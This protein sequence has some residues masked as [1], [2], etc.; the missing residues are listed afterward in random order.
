M[1]EAGQMRFYLGK[2]TFT[3]ESIPDDY[4]GCAG[5]AQIDRLQDVLLH[6]CR[7]GHRH[8]V[9]VTPGDVMAPTLDAMVNYLGYQVNVPQCGFGC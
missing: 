5:V 2:G 3:G 9:S 7:A 4:F 1:T 8:H 6:I